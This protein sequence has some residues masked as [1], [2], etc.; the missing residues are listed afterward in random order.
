[1]LL[2][3]FCLR[4]VLPIPG[5]AADAGDGPWRWGFWGAFF[6]LALAVFGTG[7]ALA[8]LAS[9]GELGW[10]HVIGRDGFDFERCS[11]G[12]GEAE[13]PAEFGGPPT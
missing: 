12:V 3:R 8:L 6:G 10:R 11:L 5:G 2:T 9:G 7:E 4:L 13:F 1:M